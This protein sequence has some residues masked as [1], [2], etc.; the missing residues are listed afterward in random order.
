MFDLN[1]STNI[2][3]HILQTWRLAGHSAAGE[4]LHEHH[5]HSSAMS[6]QQCGR[7]LGHAQFEAANTKFETMPAAFQLHNYVWAWGIRHSQGPCL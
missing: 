7:A 4:L 5:V 6:C 2:Q 1:D 3:R